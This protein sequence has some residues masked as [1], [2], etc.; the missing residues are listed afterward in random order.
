MLCHNNNKDVNLNYPNNSLIFYLHNLS[1]V[2]SFGFYNLANK[3]MLFSHLKDEEIEH[4]IQLSDLSKFIE[5]VFNGAKT[6][7]QVP[8]ELISN[9]KIKC[10]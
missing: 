7:F 4:H 8:W 9:W 2:L 1:T 3:G 5:L 6:E 10:H